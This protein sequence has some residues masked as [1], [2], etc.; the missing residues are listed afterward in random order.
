MS[1]EPLPATTTPE[2]AQRATNLLRTYYQHW[3]AMHTEWLLTL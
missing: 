3:V 2:A 1:D